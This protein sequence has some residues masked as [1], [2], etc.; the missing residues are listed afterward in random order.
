MN[1]SHFIG[2]TTLDLTKAQIPVGETRVYVSCFIG[3]VKVFV[4]NDPG[5]GVQVMSSSLIGDVRVWDQQRGGFFN[6]LSVE[7]PGF[8]DAEKRVVLIASAFIGDVR[9]TKVG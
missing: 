4:P 2:D 6:Q 8:S 3:D 9:V 7:S 1:I 5:I